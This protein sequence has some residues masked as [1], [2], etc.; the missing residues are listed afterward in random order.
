MAQ[1]ALEKFKKPAF[2]LCSTGVS[3]KGEFLDGEA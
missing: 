1:S 3:V 2:I